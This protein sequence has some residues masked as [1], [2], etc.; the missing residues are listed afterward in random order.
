MKTLKGGCAMTTRNDQIVFACKALWR[1][2]PE[3]ILNPTYIKAS[4]ACPDAISVGGGKCAGCC[5]RDL[6]NLVGLYVASEYHQNI[7]RIRQM[8]GEM[9]QHPDLP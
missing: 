4:C 2:Y 7:R 3:Q 5:E 6:A 8:E 1:Q 9:L